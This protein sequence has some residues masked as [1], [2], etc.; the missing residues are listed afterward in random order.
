MQI[1]NFE[2]L[3][4]VGVA[5]FVLAKLWDVVKERLP[6]WGRLPELGREVGGYV[7]MAIN[8]G[9]MWCTGLDM[10]PGFG[11]VVPWLGRVL[12]CVVAACGPSVVY[13]MF[14]DAK[15]YVGQFGEPEPKP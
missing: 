7:I 5:S 2:I 1:I 12:T 9:L 14:L 4:V 8:G 15:K 11:A 3:V 6:F 13:D 10:L